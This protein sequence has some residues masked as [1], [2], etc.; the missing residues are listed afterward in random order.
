MLQSIHDKTKGILGIVIIGFLVMAFGLWGIGDYLTGATEKFAVKVDGVEIG[1]TQFEDALARQRQRISQMFQGRMPE[2]A[3]FEQRMKQQV[4]EQLITRQVMQKMVVDEKYRVADVVLAERIKN[5]K[6]FNQE[7]VFNKKAYQSAVA[8]QGM[9]VKEFENLYRNDLAVQQLQDAVSQS[10]FIGKAELNILNQIQ[11]QSRDINFLQFEDSYF[12]PAI[13]LSDDDIS[14]YFEAHRADYMYP[15]TVTVSYVELIGDDLI[16]NMPVDDAA[17]QKL[18]ESYRVNISQKEQRKAQHILLTL[19]VDDSED[20][21]KEKRD[22]I[23]GLLARINN[24]ESFETIAK[25][26]S[27]DSGSAPKGGDLGWI[28]KG[29]M[30][31]EFDD[32]LFKLEKNQLSGVV[33]SSFGYHLIRYTDVKSEDI[34]SFEEK[35]P[36]LIKQFNAQLIEDKFY[37]KSEAMATIAYENDQSLQ[38]VAD[39]LGLNIKTSESFSRQQGSGI[40]ENKKVRQ[41]AFTAS[42]LSDNRNSDIIEISKNHVVVLRVDTHT[43]AKS[44]GL[45]EVKPVITAVLKAKKAKQKSQAAALEALVKLEAGTPIDDSHFQA[46]A[47]LTKLG[48]IKRD[49]TEADRAIVNDAFTL[50]KPTGD[51]PVYKVVDTHDGAAIIQLNAVTVPEMATQE[52]LDVLSKQFLNEQ[53]SRDMN[54]VLGSLKS[55]SKIVRAKTL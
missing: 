48:P 52:Q 5:M 47:K 26:F 45:D 43:E 19:T 35:K 4:I 28:S 33:K 50:S 22:K 14:A 54:A 34:A 16:K 13:T 29:M 27:E 36:E 11:Q 17:I 12:L 31:P 3:A 1:L 2:G 40:A 39:E 7:G 21:K 24:G 8:S 6:A 55:K 38:E 42:V 10:A 9:T 53:A 41:A 25:E 51:K 49:N 23:E 20:V 32:A 18:Y 46:M 37:E 44:K 15:E 30:L